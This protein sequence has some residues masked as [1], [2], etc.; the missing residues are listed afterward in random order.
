MASI[1]IPE[2]SYTTTLTKSSSTTKIATTT[3]T[4]L[5][6]RHTI[7]SNTYSLHTSYTP[8]SQTTSKNRCAIYSSPTDTY[9]SSLCNS[10][11]TSTP[12]NTP[13]Y[14]PSTYNP[15]STS[16]IYLPHPLAIW[17]IIC[18]SILAFF[19]VL[20][21]VASFYRCKEKARRKKCDELAA[22]GGNDAT[23]MAEGIQI[24]PTYGGATM[25]TQQ[26]GGVP[27]STTEQENGT[28]IQPVESAHLREEGGNVTVPRPVV[29]PPLMVR[30]L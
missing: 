13:F 10:V 9:L 3:D 1:V 14:T 5:P 19:T 11:Y 4:S 12:T 24:P 25:G 17:K 18:I 23:A 16:S 15:T 21:S 6:P 28:V 29:S 26:N 27:I 30:N 7:F 22:L 20:F 8:S 2:D